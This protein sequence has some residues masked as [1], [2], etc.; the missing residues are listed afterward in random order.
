MPRPE[1]RALLDHSFKIPILASI[2]NAWASTKYKNS[3]LKDFDV[4]SLIRKTEKDK[5]FSQELLNDFA[6][7]V[8]NG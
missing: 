7:K 5:G 2:S 8:F 1:G 3:D 4:D 6:K